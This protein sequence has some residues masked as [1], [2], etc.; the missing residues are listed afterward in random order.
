MGAKWAK[1]SV[2]TVRGERGVIL[3]PDD[4]HLARQHP[5][6]YLAG[7]QRSVNI[8]LEQAAND[9][10]FSRKEVIGIGVDTTGSTP[11]PVDAS[12]QALALLPRFED[13][14]DAMAWLWKDH[15][16]HQEAAEI[17]CGRRKLRPQYLAKCGGR[18]SSEWFW[19]KILHCA[20]S[21]P[22]VSSAAA[23]WVEIADWIPAV[24]AGTTDLSNCA[25]ASAPPA[26]RR[27]T[28]RPGAATRR[29]IPR[30]SCIRA[31][32][33]PPILPSVLH[34]RGAGRE[35]V[36]GVGPK[37]ELS[38]G[39]PLPSGRSTRIWAVGAGIGPGT[40]VKVM[41]TSTCDVMVAPTGA[42]RSPISRAFAASSPSRSCPGIF[43]LEAGQSAV[44]DIF[45]WFVNQ[46]QPGGAEAG[47]HAEA[48]RRSQKLRPGQSGLLCARL[49]QRKSHHPGRSAA[50]AA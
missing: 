2:I 41:G 42:N 11:L 6:D 23:S 27:F 48:D 22:D 7:I 18:Y 20:E 29:R 9:R 33:H 8:A 39:F 1:A 12:G 31:G 44:G 4:P 47:T 46:V 19:A 24:L 40:L 13:D 15:T 25:A 10:D 16:S 49:A 37:L 14:P 43:G 30:H 17:T 36:A 28:T 45:N 21:P 34:R 32:A 3:S 35:L 38:K 26:T 50:H 5:A